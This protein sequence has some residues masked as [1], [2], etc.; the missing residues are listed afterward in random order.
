[1]ENF[2]YSINAT[3]PVFLVMII[4]YILKQMDIL[5]EHFANKAN[6]FN[7]KVTLPCLVFSD[8]ASTDMKSTFDLSFVLFCAI[9]TSICFWGIWGVS[10]IFLKD[11]TIRGAFVQAAFRGSAAVFGIAFIVN[12]YGNSGMAPM[13]I[14][15][16]VPLYNIYSVIVLTFEANDT[17]NG[18]SNLKNALLNICKN[19]IL[20]SILFACI[21]SLTGLYQL[22]PVI[23]T[24]TIDNFAKMAS[25]LALV[26]IGVT[27]EG[28]SA[29][30]KLKPAL[31]ASIYKVL[32]QPAIF[33]PIA[34]SM[35]FTKEK[36]IAILI[37]LGSPTTPS[38]YIMAKNMNNDADLT[39]GSILV[40]TLFSTF[41][42][43]F[44]I[45]LAKSM[46]YI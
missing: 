42:I 20:L 24:K 29:I 9:V 6:K 32:L 1:M 8:L 10:R 21:W 7:F 14:L 34:I 41:T 17:T 40:S 38:C 22:T 15:G 26:C 37:M 44:W 30:A 33:L 2:I 45:Y 46:G 27:F 13:M 43:T 35:G 23:V 16:A 39:A 4:G 31:I 18:S 12:I 36:L 25:P 19:P 3:I 11:K 5:D 28:R